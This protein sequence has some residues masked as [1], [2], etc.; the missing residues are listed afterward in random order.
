MLLKNFMSTLVA[1]IYPGTDRARAVRDSLAPMGASLLS[2]VVD[3]VIV[4]RDDKGK[5]HLDQE[6][7]LV[8]TGAAKGMLWPLLS[9]LPFFAPLLL[10]NPSAF[11][12]PLA[13]D[14]REAE[15]LAID[16]DYD[17][18]LDYADNLH[19]STNDLTPDEG[20]D[21]GTIIAE[22]D[23]GLTDA[24][25]NALDGAIQPNT[26][27]LFLLVNGGDVENV[28][29]ILN[30]SGGALFQTGLSANVVAQIRR[31]LSHKLALA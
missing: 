11:N 24:F 9:G 16:N 27:T 14:I 15:E 21:D 2:D 12:D 25:V 19:P 6:V 18:D 10:D 23:N 4:A 1:I 17:D 13:R 31:A 30:P 3:V 20:A 22:V 29:T 26:S 28:Q 5:M 8:E 7:A